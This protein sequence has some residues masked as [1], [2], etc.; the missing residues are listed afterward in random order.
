MSRII[1]ISLALV[2]AALLLLGTW[3]QSDIRAEQAAWNR[4]AARQTEPAERFDPAMTAG[5][6]DAA[7]RFFRYAIEP[8][9]PLFRVAMVSMEGEFGLGNKAKP[10]YL[11][12]RAKQILAAPYGFV[13]RVHAGDAVRI[14]GSDGLEEG[15][16]WSRFWLFGFAPV[17]RAGGNPDHARAAFGRQV[18]EAIFWT[19]AALLPGKNIVWEAIDND[20]ARVTLTYQGLE[21]AVDLY[22]DVDGRP[23]KVIFQRWSDANPD[24]TFQLQ[25]FGGYPSKFERFG[26]YRLP[27]R[28][29]AGNFFGTDEYFPFFRVNVTSVRFP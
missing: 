23:V 8:G 21:Q 6:P 9:T 2:S 12:M 7:Q 26:G 25:P 13:W 11:P 15:S 22:V 19:P 18:A 20:A 10:G 5:L 28:I 24:K 29:E 14:S 17:A 3:R 27:T 4:L 16:G 1:P